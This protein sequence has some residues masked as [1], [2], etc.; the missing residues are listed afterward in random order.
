MNEV[1]GTSVTCETIGHIVVASGRLLLVDPAVIADWVD[2]EAIDDLYDLF[3]WGE[4]EEALSK[5]LG[6]PL[7]VLLTGVPGEQAIAVEREALALCRK[8][9]W[10]VAV[11]LRPRSHYW[12]SVA[13]T[14]AATGGEL[15]VG[16]RAAVVVA[17][18]DGRYPV[19]VERS[20]EGAITR[21]VVDFGERQ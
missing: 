10:Q 9:G 20:P 11:E 7:P 6:L 16:D 18:G 1:M 8:H 21:L 19:R 12:Q 5:A 17:P 14:S 13:L 4:D 2:D 3:A 15:V